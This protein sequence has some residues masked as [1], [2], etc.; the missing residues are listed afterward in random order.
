M[1]CSWATTQSKRTDDRFVPWK[2]LSQRP[3]GWNPDINDGVRMSI[4][5]FV[6]ADILRQKVKIK[7]EK[8]RGAESQRNRAEYSWFWSGSTFTGN[9]LNDVNPTREQKQRASTR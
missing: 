4:R 9:R 3:I 2:P 5:P 1:S 6:E 7:W 8:D